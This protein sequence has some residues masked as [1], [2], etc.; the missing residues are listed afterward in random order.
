MCWILTIIKYNIL[1]VEETRVAQCRKLKK[2]QYVR[3]RPQN[4]MLNISQSKGN[5]YPRH[6]GFFSHKAM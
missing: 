2:A 1:A 4:I 6:A 3:C 5:G